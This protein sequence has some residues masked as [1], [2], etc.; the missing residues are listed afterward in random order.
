MLL[1]FPGGAPADPHFYLIDHAAYRM[2]DF[3][4]DFVGFLSVH[5]RAGKAVL[6]SKEKSY[7]EQRNHDPESNNKQNDQNQ[8]G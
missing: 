4:H 5:I 8:D 2:G 7:D 3:I 1:L 6:A